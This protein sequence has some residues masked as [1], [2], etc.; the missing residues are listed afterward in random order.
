[1]SSILSKSVDSWQEAVAL[2]RTL[3]QDD[4]VIFSPN[5]ISSP[6]K[7]VMQ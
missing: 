3:V 7:R 1:M 6:N 2:P 4:G 5:A